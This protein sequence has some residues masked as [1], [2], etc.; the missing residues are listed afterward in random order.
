MNK[1]FWLTVPLFLYAPLLLAADP[2]KV[3]GG[4]TAWMLASATLVLFMTLPGL[5]LFYGGLVRA[6]NVL[7]VLMQCSS[8]LFVMVHGRT[9]RKHIPKK[10][11]CGSRPRAGGG[12]GL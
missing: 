12:P 5:A 1:R 4:D 10:K 2:A 11:I 8:L 9:G 3:D 6:K 7:S